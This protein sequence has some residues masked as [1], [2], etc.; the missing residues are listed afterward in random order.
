ME[1]GDLSVGE[2]MIAGSVNPRRVI[3][4]QNP[5]ANI[6]AAVSPPPSTVSNS[7]MAPSTLFNPHLN[8]FLEDILH[9]GPITP[10]SL[11]S[12]GESPPSDASGPS[13]P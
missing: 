1:E 2:V 8:D 5:I 12:V 7:S 3:E 10:S 9:E 4:V 13:P 11:N 6:D